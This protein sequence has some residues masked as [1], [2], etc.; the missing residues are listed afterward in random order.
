M[1]GPLD[2]LSYFLPNQQA[3]QEYNPFAQAAPISD[4]VNKLTMQAVQADPVGY[5]N[6]AIKVSL[7]NGLL[8]GIFGGLAQQRNSELTNN[9][10]Q[11]VQ[12][13][14]NGQPVT[15]ESSGLPEGLFG[16]ARQGATV[17]NLQK[18]LEEDEAKK[19]F[20]RQVALNNARD[21]LPSSPEL[22][23]IA[24]LQSL[25]PK[26]SPLPDPTVTVDPSAQDQ[27]IYLGAQALSPEKLTA[28]GIPKEEQEFIKNQGDL[29]L[30]D[31]KLARDEMKQRAADRI[32]L[33]KQKL[34]QLE[35]RTLS[36]EYIHDPAYK[37]ALI[38]APLVSSSY[39]LASKRTP[40]GDLG[41]VDNLVRA[42]NPQGVLRSKLV[43]MIKDAQNPLHKWSGKIQ[44]VFN[45]GLFDDTTRQQMLDALTTRVNEGLQVA[46][47]VADSKIARATLK[48]LDPD[49]I[50]DPNHYL[51]LFGS[52]GDE[53]S[54]DSAQ[55]K[56]PTRSEL[57]AQGYHYDPVT[58]SMV[59]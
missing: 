38:L 39:E 6:E 41:L 20:A 2:F 55:S 53:S 58:R 1:A 8:S 25:I 44:N 27:G 10:I 31:S 49:T 3:V 51:S 45:G 40:Q 16:S 26:A 13:L 37:N 19:T 15:A 4:S 23:K 43:E 32:E 46:K 36:S 33:Q 48:G 12:G 35:A 21:G 17:F 50:I 30:F 57:E 59:K 34:N 9:Y 18:N 28:L 7:I 29:K 11:A 24:G 14:T 5:R 54:T 42:Y 47:G 56:I 22:L 52:L